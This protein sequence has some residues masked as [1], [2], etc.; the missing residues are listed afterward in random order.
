M[1][2]GGG[3]DLLPR[4]YQLLHHHQR[5][6]NARAQVQKVHFIIII[7]FVVYSLVDCLNLFLILG[8][9][10]PKRNANATD[11]S[12]S[13]DESKDSSVVESE[14]PAK[15][16]EAEAKTNDAPVE[17]N[18]HDAKDEAANNNAEAAKVSWKVCVLCI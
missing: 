4:V 2:A 10:R 3:R 8:R 1:K 11:E 17:N 9:G 18:T 7:S 13:H 12:D 6:K 15:N 5:R 16:A 14:E